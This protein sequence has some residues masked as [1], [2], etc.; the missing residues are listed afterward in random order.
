MNNKQKRIQEFKECLGNARNI[1]EIERD[2]LRE[3]KEENQ[4]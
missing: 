1:Y 2:E 3:E 4:E